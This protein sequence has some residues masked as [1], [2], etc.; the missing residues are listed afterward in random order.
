MNRYNRQEIT[1][2]V[3]K[4]KKL[5]SSSITIVGMGALGTLCAQLLSRAGVGKIKIIDFD[6]VAHQEIPK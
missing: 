3:E 5:S 1:L 6:K 4:Q 2:G